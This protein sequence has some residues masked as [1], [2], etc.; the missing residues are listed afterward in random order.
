LTETN[1]AVL[2]AA[3]RSVPESLW[4]IGAGGAR[5][6]AWLTPPVGKMAAGAKVPLILFVHGGPQ[7]SWDDRFHWR[8]N[9]QILAGAGY[10]VLQP[11]PRGSTGYGQA[12]VD[13]I[14]GDW[15]GKVYEDLMRSVDQVITTVPWVD[16]TRVAAAGGSF[17]G[18]MMY[19]MAGHTDR[20]RCLVSHAGLY[21]LE[22]FYGATEELWFPE[23]EFMGTPWDHPE[24]YAQWSPR[25]SVRGWKTPMLVT[26]GARDYRVPEA[27]GFAAF[28]ALQ[29]RGIP[30]E[31]LWFAG[32][33]HFIVK[34]QN[35]ILWY[36]TMIGWFDRWLGPSSGSGSARSTVSEGTRP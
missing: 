17:G 34:P 27:Q 15:G 29:R 22:S 24:S 7:G 5:V 10:A 25:H 35:S 12:F 8:W 26:E 2:A 11:D 20:F 33:N 3:Q 9:P 4:C 28:T 23:W 31:L 18:Y 16:S 1:T 32:E 21:D 14:N 19:W 13:G 6:H 30:S 36:D